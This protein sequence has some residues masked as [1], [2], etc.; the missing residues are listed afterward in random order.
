VDGVSTNA[1]KFQIK[2]GKSQ[3]EPFGVVFIKLK[4]IVLSN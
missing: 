2:A 1:V 4:M 3:L